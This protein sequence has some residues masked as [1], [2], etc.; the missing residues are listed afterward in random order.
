MTKLLVNARTDGFK[1]QF[2]NNVT[3]IKLE[4]GPS[5]YRLD[6]IGDVHVASVQW[7][8]SA[9]GYAYLMAFFRTEIQYGALPF[10]VDLKAVD[11]DDLTTYTAHFVPGSM[12][13][14]GLVG[15]VYTVNAQ[16]E[17]LPLALDSGADQA[18]IN[19]GPGE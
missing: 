9:Q 5:R 17:L 6:K 18:L 13:L 8:R 14:T 4:G 7:V 12:Q 19:G 10:E 16:L 3:S 11:S 1:L 2:G 15:E